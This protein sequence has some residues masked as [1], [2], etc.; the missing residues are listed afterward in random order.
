LNSE[1]SFSEKVDA[2][3]NKRNEIISEA[4]ML[5]GAINQHYFQK[6]KENDIIDIERNE[7]LNEIRNAANEK[8]TDKL[9]DLFERLR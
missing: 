5:I 2:E 4:D 6:Q 9:D 8:D 1:A 3:I 7:L